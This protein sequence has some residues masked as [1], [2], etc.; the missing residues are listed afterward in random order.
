MTGTEVRYSETQPGSES[1]EGLPEEV[2]RVM[3]D[4]VGLMRGWYVVPLFRFRLN[5]EILSLLP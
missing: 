4:A 5:G 1:F 3:L 2:K